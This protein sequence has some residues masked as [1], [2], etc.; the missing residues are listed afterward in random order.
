MNNPNDGI[1]ATGLRLQ[2]LLTASGELELSLDTAP[3]DA[4]KA[5]EVIVRV[6]AAPV[7]PS[8]LGLLL[9]GADV[10][11]ARTT[12]E[13]TARRTILSVPEA[14]RRAM[15]GRVGAP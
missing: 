10:S 15:A 6:E 1:P 9:G 8:D 5:G 13:G 11:T 3:I 12:G 2:S 14:G 7:N 4:P